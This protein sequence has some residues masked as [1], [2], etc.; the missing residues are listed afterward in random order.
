LQGRMILSSDWQLD[1][2]IH[3]FRFIPGEGSLFFLTARWNAMSRTIKILTTSQHKGQRCRLDLMES[4]TGISGLKTFQQSASFTVLRSGIL[5]APET[6][7]AYVFQFAMNI[8]CPGKTFVNYEG[9]VYTTLQ[10]LSQCWLKENL[11]AGTMIPGTIEQSNNGTMEKYC[12]G[13]NVA[14]CDT[15]GGLYQWNEA[16]QYNTGQWA[17]GICPP[18]W[19]LPM[20]EEWK[21]LEGAID[22]QYGFAD[23]EW[24]GEGYRGYNVGSGL[25][26]AGTIHWNPPNY[27][28]TNASG[29]TGLPGGNRD[30]SSGDFVNL[31]AGGSLWSSSENTASAWYRAL[32]YASPH[33]Y[34][35]YVDKA[36]GYSVR[37]LKGC[38]PVIAHAGENDAT[39]E[40]ME[41]PLSGATAA[42][43]ASLLWTT[44]GTGSFDDPASLNPIYTPSQEDLLM[45]EVT[46]TLAAS[47]GGEC[48]DASSAMTL[49]IHAAPTANAGEDADICSTQGTYTLSGTAANYSTL[50]WTTSG[51]GMFNDPSAPGAAY[52]PSPV[53]KTAGLIYLILTAQ[54]SGNCNPVTDTME[55]KIW[56][57]TANA[58][59]DQMS[60][61]GTST[62]LEG[63]APTFGN[64][65]WQIVS[66]TSGNISDPDDPHSGFNGLS[67]QT[68]FLTWNISNM[69]CGTST[70]TVMISFFACGMDWLYEGQSYSTVLIGSQCWFQENLNVGTMI[71]SNTEG[72]LQTDNGVIEKYCYNNVANYCDT[73]GG[74][75]EWPEAMQYVTTEGAQGICPEGWH[76]PTHGEFTVLTD[77]LGGWWIAGGKMKSTG[78]IEEGTGLWHTPNTGATNESGWTG[79]P[80]GNRVGWEGSFNSLG[81]LGWWFTSTEGSPTEAARRI[82]Y[83]NEARVGAIEIYDG[84]Y[85]TMGYSIRCLQ[86]D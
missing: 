45:A 85:K 62:T 27:G 28:A 86:D 60:I 82:L 7:K 47:G 33:S 70:D 58:G 40:N 37:C 52:T 32:N 41:Y 31:G 17:K 65:L 44:S 42:N 48:P 2:G 54:G 11:N 57:G 73:Y 39:C 64:G 1:Q 10:I 51:S 78:T 61:I 80:G 30:Y 74:L 55:L 71:I 29:F 59:P 24:D 12:Y 46:L 72:F 4:E 43:Y 8:P 35:K 76:I 19:H 83:S 56:T 21:V 84:F 79:H 14:N 50:L 18:G 5:D 25:K 77:F 63:N 6:D 66:G 9:K 49:G 15:Y 67:G 75:Y 38:V 36:A 53:D 3:S 23:M 22:G 16:M 13:D 34:R 20:D 81:E 69:A 26:E 68:Y